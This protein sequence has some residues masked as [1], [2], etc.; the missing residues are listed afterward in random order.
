MVRS[1]KGFPLKMMMTHE[2]DEFFTMTGTTGA[3]ATY[4]F[5]VNGMFDPNHTSTGI[6][7]LYFD[8][9]TP[10]YNHYVVFRS[11]CTFEFVNDV[12]AHVAVYVDD[13][14]TLVSGVRT[15]L[16][17]STGKGGIYPVPTTASH[18]LHLGWDAKRYFGGDIY[19]NS[20]LKGYINTD[21]N[22]LSY[23]SILATASAA[24]GTLNM[25]VRVKI[26]YHAVWM[27]VRSIADS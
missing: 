25:S 12:P 4:Q 3:L 26:L 19:D 21:P 20:N 13:D 18:K 24:A 14:A 7:P 2:Y 15:A 6:Q 23:F 16:T 17:Q 27:E 9:M 5:K 1:P 11:T 8:Q 22:E 10:I